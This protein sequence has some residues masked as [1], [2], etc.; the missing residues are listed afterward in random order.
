MYRDLLAKLLLITALCLVD[1]PESHQLIH[2]NSKKTNKK[3]PLRKW[4]LQY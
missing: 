2:E 3:K 1:R 4:P